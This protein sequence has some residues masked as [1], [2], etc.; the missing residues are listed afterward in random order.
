MK[1]RKFLYWAAP[2]GG[3]LC[4][5]AVLRLAIGFVSWR[6]FD[7]DNRDWSWCLRTYGVVFFVAFVVA[8]PAWIALLRSRAQKEQRHD[9]AA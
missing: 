4:L 2:L 9:R 1:Q 7:G 8:L 6:W 5:Y 3:F